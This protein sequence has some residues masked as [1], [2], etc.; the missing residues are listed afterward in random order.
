MARLGDIPAAEAA[1]RIISPQVHSRIDLLSAELKEELGL[2]PQEAIH[3]LVKAAAATGN[4]KYLTPAAYLEDKWLHEPVSATRWI[5]DPEYFGH[6][7]ANMWDR[8]KEDFL[9]IMESPTRPLRVAL[10]GSIGWGKSFLS[11]TIASRLLYEVLCLRGPQEFYGLSMTSWIS[12]MNLA[13]SASH[14]RRVFFSQLREMIDGSKWFRQRMCRNMEVASFLTWPGRRV[15]WVPGSSSELSALGENL[16]GGVIEEANFF[17]VSVTSKKIRSAAER[18]WDQ[19]KKLQDSMWRR[20]TSRYARM[21]RVPGMLILNSSASYPDDFME[22]IVKEN[23][24]Y[25]AVINHAEWETKPPSRFCGKTFLVFVGDQSHSPKVIENDAEAERYGKIGKVM[26]VPVEYISSFRRDLEGSIR[27]VMGVNVRSSNRFFT[28]VEALARA[29][30][31]TTIPVPFRQEYAEGIDAA[32]INGAILYYKFMEPKILPGKRPKIKLHPNAPRFAHIDLGISN[33]CA[34]L[35]VCH[36]GDMVE[37]ERTEDVEGDVRVVKE[38]LPVIYVDLA[39]RLIPPVEG[40]IQIEDVRTILYD[41]RDKCGFNFIRITYDQFQSKESMQTLARRFGE[42]TVGLLSVQKTA[43]QYIVL[44]EAIYEGRLKCYAYPPLVR[45]LHGLVY[46]PRTN[47][48]DHLPNASKDVADALAGAVWNAVT[49]ADYAVRDHVVRAAPVEEK[50]IEE[51]LAEEATGWLLGMDGKKREKDP[52]DEET[53][54]REMA[55]SDPDFKD[56][57]RESGGGGFYSGW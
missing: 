42:D 20:M 21:G 44:K 49:N 55:E 50:T 7:G 13:I 31:D 10:T 8:L 25:T 47:K 33:D 5:S 30:T 34:G 39:L 24:P 45:E 48:V 52:L 28:N 4:K 35:C 54:E 3:L 41:L 56:A 37:M 18:E 51:K 32:F 19:A 14:A 26:P 1:S 12:F 6:V 38:S 11:A 27:D 23:D 43:D 29:F 53:L 9:K 2:T 17:Q 40:E 57:D 22:K 36:I 46:D 15:S 16:F